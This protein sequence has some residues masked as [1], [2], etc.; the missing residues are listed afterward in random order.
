MVSVVILFKGID[1]SMLA[2]GLDVLN[3]TSVSTSIST[4][5]GLCRAPKLLDKLKCE[6]KVKT[7]EELGVEA[8]SLACSTLGRV[9]GRA[10]ASGWD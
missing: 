7:I 10:R 3:K 9:E 2:L 8:R 6:S 5:V 4:I 1:L